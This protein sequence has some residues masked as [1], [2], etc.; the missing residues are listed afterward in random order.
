M[1]KHL[2]LS[3]LAV[4]F[5]SGCDEEKKAL[6]ANPSILDVG[7]YDG[8]SVKYVNRGW[9]SQSFYIARCGNTTTTTNNAM[10]K[11]GKYTVL[12]RRTAI[13]MEEQE[14]AARLKTKQEALNKLTT[15][16]R[17]ALGLE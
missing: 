13:T 7:E 15:E 4:L 17:T 1:R 16:E 11:S 12:R 9:D 10:V 2:I 5:L 14:I 8:C 6:F 3:F